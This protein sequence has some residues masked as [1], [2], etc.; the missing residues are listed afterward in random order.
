MPLRT[1]ALR[2]RLHDG[3]RR[4]RSPI[5]RERGQFA[6]EEAARPHRYRSEHI[7]G[8]RGRDANEHAAPGKRN[9]ADLGGTGEISRP[10]KFLTAAHPSLNHRA[11]AI[12][13]ENQKTE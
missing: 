1:T 5:P 11:T 13:C 10:S 4:R 2:C 9:E 7:E 12:G 8:G 3:T 6:F